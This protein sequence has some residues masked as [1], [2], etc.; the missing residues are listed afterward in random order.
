MRGRRRVYDEPINISIKCERRF[1]DFMAFLKVSDTEV[2]MKGVLAIMAERATELSP[3]ALERA[4]QELRRK[5][6][7]DQ[8][9]IAHCERVIMDRKIQCEQVKRKKT[10]VE[11]WDGREVVLMEAE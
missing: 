4:G 7:D 10:R 8:D 1:H 3:E 6:K 11:V 9:R 2:Y 5:M